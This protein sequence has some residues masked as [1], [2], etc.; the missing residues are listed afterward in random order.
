MCTGCIQDAGQCGAESLFM[1]FTLSHL[2]IVIVC[3]DT[4]EDVISMV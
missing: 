3:G 1:K 2:L 4:Q